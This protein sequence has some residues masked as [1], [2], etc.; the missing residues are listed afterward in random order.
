MC[1]I[2]QGTNNHFL[3]PQGQYSLFFFSENYIYQGMPMKFSGVKYIKL[4]GSFKCTYFI[5]T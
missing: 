2:S 1:F 3:V 5:I 4:W